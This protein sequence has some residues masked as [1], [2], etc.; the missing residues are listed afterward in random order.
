[1]PPLGP[2]GNPVP[3]AQLPGIFIILTIE[4]ANQVRML[5]VAGHACAPVPLKDGTLILPIRLLNDPHHVR[6]RNFLATLPQRS[7]VWNTEL[8]DGEQYPDEV[9]ACT[10]DS[11][12]KKGEAVV[13]ALPAR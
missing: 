2:D 4:D 9:Q 13:V 10:Y 5:T 6:H 11:S 8:A 12:W 7:D 3:P 1:M